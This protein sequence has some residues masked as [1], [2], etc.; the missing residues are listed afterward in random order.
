[1]VMNVYK[2]FLSL[3][4]ETGAKNTPCG[5]K[6]NDLTKTNSITFIFL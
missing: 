3:T 6:D 5:E 4:R 1:M 2:E